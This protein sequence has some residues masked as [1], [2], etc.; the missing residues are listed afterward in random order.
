MIAQPSSEVI[1]VDYGCQQGTAV[2]ARS[3]HP[4]VK[5]VEVRD[6]PVF[7]SARARNLGAK[8]AGNELL[9]FVDADVFVKG[10]LAKWLSENHRAGRFVVSGLQDNELGGFFICERQVLEK[11]G[12]YDE[13]FR[14]WGNEDSDLYERLELAGLARTSI[15]P[16]F[17]SVIRHGDDERQLGPGTDFDDLRQALILGELYK[18]IKRDLTRYRGQE[19]DLETRRKIMQEITALHK[20]ALRSGQKQFTF[21]ITLPLQPEY[22]KFSRYA[23]GFFYDVLS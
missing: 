6:D 8:T 9:C 18:A 11:V 3:N 5:V 13:A 10:D 14:A 2:W 21:S 16:E 1:V 20:A 19:P 7:C 22:S 23:H 4:A 12:G 17:I 15:P